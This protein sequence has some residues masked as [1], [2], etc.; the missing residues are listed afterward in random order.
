VTF[1]VPEGEV[2]TIGG[3]VMTKLNRI[4]RAGDKVAIEEYEITVDQMDGPRVVR[5][6]IQPRLGVPTTNVTA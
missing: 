6:R 5:V 1:D 4:P 3:Y 2:T